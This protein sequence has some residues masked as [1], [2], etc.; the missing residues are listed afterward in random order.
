MR[1]ED[2]TGIS[3]TGLVAWGMVFPDGHAVTRWCATAR[4]QTCVWTDLADVEFV[5]GHNGAT[6]IVW[7]DPEVGVSVFT[8]EVPSGGVWLDA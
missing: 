3:G 6:E 4:R 8:G 2:L 7:L 1:H 5:H